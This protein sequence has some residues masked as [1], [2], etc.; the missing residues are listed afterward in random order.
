[1]E[2]LLSLDTPSFSVLNSTVPPPKKAPNSLDDV[3]GSAKSVLSQAP[4]GNGPKPLFDNDSSAADPAS[5][6]IGILIANWTGQSGDYA[7]AA[8]NQID[9]LLNKAPRAPNG[10]ISHRADEAQL[11][12]VF[13]LVP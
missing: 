4:T 5:T 11:W 6:G 8:E 7:N 12:S 1:M 3:L 9:Y 13:C 10:A 2:A